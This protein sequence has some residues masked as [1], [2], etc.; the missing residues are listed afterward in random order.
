[1]PSR[2][3]RADR[4][5]L[6]EVAVQ[7]PEWDLDLLERLYRGRHARAPRRFREDFCSTAALAAAWVVR[8]RENRAWGV[9]L[10]A[11][12]LAWARRHRLPHL[13]EAARRVTLSRH[14]V[15][16]PGAPAV[17]VACALNFSWWVFHR[18]ADLLAYLRAARAGLAPGGVL[19]LNAFGGARAERALTERTRKAASCAAD[20]SPVP[21]FTYV[22]EQA[23]FE[24]LTRNLIAHIHFELR[25]GRVLRRAFTYDWR[26]YTLPEIRE[27]A[28]EAG[29]RGFEIWS[30]GW[31]AKRRTHTGV[32]HRR[33]HLDN[34]DCWIAYCAAWR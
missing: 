9:D 32:V 34:D 25:D 16:R 6:Y 14:D 31:D 15:R 28:L 20:G 11:E 19:V 29:F 13:R 33:A 8:H 3:P 26:M 24:P 7:G 10:D 4:H 2:A 18:R 27:A 12:P 21:A 17:D 5:A 22:W 1:M 30:E 23:R